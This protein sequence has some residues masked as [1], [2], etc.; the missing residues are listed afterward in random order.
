MCE[1]STF[2][3]K[4]RLLSRI[5]ASDEITYGREVEEVLFWI[6]IGIDAEWRWRF[7]FNGSSSLKIYSLNYL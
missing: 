2:Y 5:S 7:Y 1:Y 4:I 3:F 6:V